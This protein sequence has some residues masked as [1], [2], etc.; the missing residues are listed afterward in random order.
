MGCFL[1]WHY[2]AKCNV[3]SDMYP[4][5]KGITKLDNEQKKKP[6]ERNGMIAAHLCVLFLFFSVNALN[7]LTPH[8]CEYN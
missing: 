1:L 3:Q 5:A 7:R 6:E 4:R 8:Y 2:A